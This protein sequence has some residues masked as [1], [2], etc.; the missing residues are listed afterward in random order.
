M[1][2]FRISGAHVNDS[3]MDIF[4]VNPIST[5][6]GRL[7]PPITSGSSQI[8][9]F[10]HHG[11]ATG[12]NFRPFFVDGIFYRPTDLSLL[13]GVSKNFGFQDFQKFQE[14]PAYC[15]LDLMILV[16]WQL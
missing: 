13:K 9:T 10:R 1:F 14:I 12:A 8:F 15:G 4:A 3:A 2:S 5:G 7:C 11:S 6:K 16:L